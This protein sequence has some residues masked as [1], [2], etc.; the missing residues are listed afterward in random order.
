MQSLIKDFNE[1]YIYIYITHYFETILGKVRFIM[2]MIFPMIHYSLYNFC[3]LC[4]I[5]EDKNCLG[6]LVN[7]IIQDYLDPRPPVN[8]SVFLNWKNS[9]SLTGITPDFSFSLMIN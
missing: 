7:Q 3:Y 8:I 4:Q 9:L 2:A 5:I 6:C 1:S